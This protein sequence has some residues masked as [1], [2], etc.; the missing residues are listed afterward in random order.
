MAYRGEHALS[1][2]SWNEMDRIEQLLAKEPPKISIIEGA[3]PRKPG[4]VIQ[5]KN[6]RLHEIRTDP[7]IKFVYGKNGETIHDKACPNLKGMDMKSLCTSDVFLMRLKPCQECFLKACIRA[8]GDVAELKRYQRFFDKVEIKDNL[9]RKIYLVHGMKSEILGD[10]LTLKHQQDTWKIRIKGKNKVGT[11]YVELMQK[12]F[13]IVDRKR[14]FTQ[15]YHT[16][17]RNMTMRE[18]I[19]Y[20]E[21]YVWRKPDDVPFSVK[22]NFARIRK[23]IKHRLTRIKDV[24]Y[25]DGDNMVQKRLAGIEKLTE[26]SIVKIFSSNAA[27]AYRSPRRQRKLRAKCQ[28]QI[29]FHTVVNGKDATDFAIAMDITRELSHKR[30]WKKG[31]NYYLVSGDKHFDVISR[32]IDQLTDYQAE[33]CW[34]KSIAEG[35][36]EK[37]NA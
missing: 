24:Y 23:W 2:A 13:R 33:A 36:E 20:I 29:E 22:W 25:I 8:G 1:Y 31:R 17:H 11:Q 28:C 34:R 19:G 21:G 3:A 16:I 18:A 35:K 9:L 27:D 37:E 26:E 32:Q 4:L 15:G 10:V 7:S 6:M 14:E 30:R 5:E 12:N